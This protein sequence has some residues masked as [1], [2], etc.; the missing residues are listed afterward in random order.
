VTTTYCL[1]YGNEG[2]DVLY[3]EPHL[4]V[5]PLFCDAYDDNFNLC[6]NSPARDFTSNHYL[7]GSCRQTCPACTAPV[8]ATSWGAIKAMFR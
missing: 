4:Y 7:L 2:G 1:A 5:D 6:V 8:Q 3:G